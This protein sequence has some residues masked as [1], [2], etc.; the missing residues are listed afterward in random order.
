MGQISQNLSPPLLICL[1]SCINFIYFIDRAII[2][3]S[4]TTF[5][6]FTALT[7]HT[8]NTGTWY[9]LVNSVFII[10]FTA[11]I[12]VVGQLVHHIPAM[13]IVSLGMV[14]HIIAVILSGLAFYANSFW[15]LLVARVLSG[16]GEASFSCIAPVYIN[17]RI[18]S[19]KRG[20]CY[21]IMSIAGNVGLGIGYVF[22]A[23]VSAKLGWQSAFFLQVILLIPMLC[24]CV[25][26]DDLPLHIVG[27]A[28]LEDTQVKH[29]R[30]SL[31]DLE[32]KEEDLEVPLP[33]ALAVLENM[34]TG[35]N[36]IADFKMMLSSPV[37]V[38]TVLGRCAIFFTVSGLSVYAPALLIA[39]GL[40]KTQADSSALLS[41]IVILS[42]IFGC[43]VSGPLFDRFS[44]KED[45]SHRLKVGL[46]QQNM[47]CIITFALFVCLPFISAKSLFMVLAFFGLAAF[48]GSL[49]PSFFVTMMI[50]PKRSRPFAYGLENGCGHVFGDIPSPIIIGFLIDTFKHEGVQGFQKVFLFLNLWLLWVIF[51]WTIATLYHICSCSSAGTTSK[52]NKANVSSQES[53]VAPS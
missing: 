36:F 53:T 24:F 4:P 23:Q 7:L 22:S 35:R 40:A 10:G 43:L 38:C 44:N 3:G 28:E 21:S 8:E 48:N 51:F 32:T 42:A 2:P 19:E 49:I 52:S 6:K 1:L 12:L 30:A 15:F 5:L 20:L 41:I 45:L 9:G 39:L 18:S 26:L 37:Y 14:L 11:T 47:Y 16:I 25:L 27:A 31:L 46:V 17:G 13:R 34:D 29:K 50:V 33:H